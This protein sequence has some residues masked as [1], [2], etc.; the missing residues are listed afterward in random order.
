L[1]LPLGPHA[2]PGRSD[3]AMGKG[4]PTKVS[5]R[6]CALI[7]RSNN[8]R[9]HANRDLP[10]SVASGPS[11]VVGRLAVARKSP[12]AHT[13]A[14]PAAARAAPEQHPPHPQL[15]SPRASRM[16][17]RPQPQAPPCEPQVAAIFAILDWTTQAIL[18]Q[19][20]TSP[21]RAGCEARRHEI[22]VIFDCGNGL[23]RD[24]PEASKVDGGL[25]VGGPQG[26]QAKPGGAPG[27]V[28]ITGR[29][30]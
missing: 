9:R 29:E 4:S 1:G 24:A 21:L 13:A 30:L 7:D 11:V 19:Q 23:A 22:A 8:A 6:H 2:S 3:R 28:R 26:L 17:L 5:S 14:A 25:R 12:R 15:A 18:G 10:L 27:P 20:H 16:C